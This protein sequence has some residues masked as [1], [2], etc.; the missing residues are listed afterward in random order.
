MINDVVRGSV[1]RYA[2]K[3][4][5]GST[6]L[7]KCCRFYQNAYENFNY[8]PTQ[9]GEYDLLRILSEFNIAYIFDVGANHGNWTN[10]A[11]SHFPAA[12]IHAFEIVGTTFNILQKNAANTAVLNNFGLHEHSGEIDVFIDSKRDD[13]ASTV[14]NA[15]LV[16]GTLSIQK[17]AIMSGDEYCATNHISYI[18]LLKIDVEGAEM[19]VMKGF[20]SNI[21][22]LNIGVI[23]WEYNECAIPERVLVKDFYDLLGGG[24]VIGKLYPGFVDFRPYSYTLE[25]FMGPNFVAVNR[26]REDIIRRLG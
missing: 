19:N 26:L 3:R 16:V 15:N 5:F 25:R 9:N 12:H 6:L 14:R 21:E 22:G 13:L 24:Y 20:R 10:E 1:W 7:Y 18:D 11:R 23:Q 17:A 4:H 2:Q 8:D